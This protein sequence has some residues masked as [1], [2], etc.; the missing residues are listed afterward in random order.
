M[1]TVTISKINNL[2]K[3]TA[4]DHAYGSEMV[5]NAVSVM[6][7]SLEAWILNNP[8][9]VKSHESDFRPG[10]A[11]IKFVATDAEVFSILDFIVTGLLQVENTYGRQFIAVNVSEEIKSLLGG[12]FIDSC[13]V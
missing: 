1:T 3:V 12:K 13:V 6:I 4:H 10:D 11:Y 2:I 9:L 7:Y 8:E 5:C